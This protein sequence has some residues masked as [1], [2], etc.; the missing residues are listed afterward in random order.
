M[1]YAMALGWLYLAGG[2]KTFGTDNS[3]VAMLMV[4]MYPKLPTT[5]MDNRF[6]L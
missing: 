6:H 3:S 5:T 4:A 2:K 1:A